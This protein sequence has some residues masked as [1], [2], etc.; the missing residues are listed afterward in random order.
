MKE[1]LL[2]L[3]DWISFNEMGFK[4]KFISYEVSETPSNIDK[5]SLRIDFESPSYI[6]RITLWDTGECF[7]EAINIKSEETEISD[8]FSIEK[9][10]N[11][12]DIFQCYLEKIVL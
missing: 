8:Y 5:T 3:K 11:L 9:A 2:K 12:N 4:N 6:S 10:D 1:L 7:V